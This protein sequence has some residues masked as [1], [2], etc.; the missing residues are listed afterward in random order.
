MAEHPFVASFPDFVTSLFTDAKPELGHCH[1]HSKHVRGADLQGDAHTRKAAELTF[2]PRTTSPMRSQK[3]L[4]NHSAG[5]IDDA[6]NAFASG[7]A[8]DELLP[9]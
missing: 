4:R 7:P 5:N 6:L 1:S 8:Q 3:K 9:R 2:D